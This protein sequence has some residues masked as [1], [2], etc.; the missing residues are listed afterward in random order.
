[1]TPECRQRAD[2]VFDQA[3][4]LEPSQWPAF[5]DSACAGDSALRAEVESMLGHYARAD[6]SGF[7]ATGATNP[8]DPGVTPA[9]WSAPPGY[10]ILTELGRGGMGVVYKARQTSL[11]RLVAIKKILH[12]DDGD[13]GEVKRLLLEAETIARFQ[14]P[15]IVQIHEV[16]LHAGSPFF[17]MELVE[18]GSLAQHCARGPLPPLQ[19][20]P[21]L[22]TLARAI[23]HAHRHGVVHRDLKPANVLL[24]RSPGCQPVAD[25]QAGSLGYEPKIADFGLAKRIDDGQQTRSGLIQGTPSYMAPEQTAGPAGAIGPCTDVYALGAILYECLTGRPPFRGASALETILLLRN[26]EPISP[27][28]LQ[29]SVPA[30]LE[31]ICLKCLDKDPGRRYDSGAAL[32]ADLERFLASEPIHAR[33]A[34]R[35]ERLLKWARRRPTAAALVIVSVLALIGLQAGVVWR[36]H[37]EKEVDAARVHTLM[38]AETAS[39]PRLIEELEPY[40]QRIEPLMWQYLADT[41][42]GSRERLHLHLALLPTHPD[43]AL[44]VCDSLLA[45]PLDDVPILRDALREHRQTQ[46]PRLW[47]VLEDGRQSPDSRFRAAVALSTYDSQENRSRWERNASFVAEQAVAVLSRKLVQFP[48]LLEAL[49]PIKGFLLTPLA[50]LFRNGVPNAKRRQATD[51]LAEMLA[52]AGADRSPFLAE[53]L[54]AAEPWQYNRLWSLVGS[55]QESLIPLLESALK[56]PPSWAWQDGSLASRLSRPDPALQQAV[57]DAEG[58]LDERFAFCQTMPLE[59]FLDVAEKLRPAGYRPLRVRPYAIDNRVQVAAVWKRD[60]KDWRLTTGKSAEEIRVQDSACQQQGYAAVDVAC[61]VTADSLAE[62]YTA[63]WCK[64]EA[65]EPASQLTVGETEKKFRGRLQ[66]L[67]AFSL[68]PRP[69]TLQRVTIGK[70]VARVNCVWR[71]TALAHT[72]NLEE[73]R[74][75]RAGGFQVDVSLWTP[76]DPAAAVK[77]AT[78]EYPNRNAPPPLE[79]CVVSKLPPTPHL[80]VCRDLATQGFRPTAI[81]A[82]SARVGDQPVTASVWA[83]PLIA[84][85]D[86]DHLARRQARAAITLLRLGRGQ[87]VWSL[88]RGGPEPR[89]RAQ[90]IHSLGPLGVPASELIARLRAATDLSEQRALVLALGEFPPDTQTPAA[91]QELQPWLLDQFRDHRDPGLHAAAGWLVRRWG[92]H[93]ELEARE[94]KLSRKDPVPDRD[95][96]VNGQ[97]QTMVVVRGANTVWM[98]SPVHEVNRGQG[99]R[100]HIQMLP[101]SFAIAATEVTQGQFNTFRSKFWYVPEWQLPDRDNVERPVVGVKWIDAVAYCQWLSEK[102][103][104]PRSQWCYPPISELK[105]GKP[106]EPVPGFLQ[107]TGYRLPTDAEWEFACRA[108]TRTSRSFGS[109]IEFLPRYAWFRGNARN[110]PQPVGRLAPNDL[111]LFDT[112]GNAWEW[113]HDLGA[114]RSGVLRGGTFDSSAETI[115]SAARIPASRDTMI[116][117]AGFRVAR[118]VPSR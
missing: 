26:Q 110:Q 35:A 7:L 9:P 80:I 112:Y 64:A 53:L 22:I 55:R 63:L 38:N 19:A 62:R 12:G 23:D 48:L 84:D 46:V 118:T 77:V 28:R 56:E 113:C 70:G 41:P 31:T 4:E 6:A 21:L 42:P 57:A 32:A 107:R 106:I 43:L 40:R 11:N 1:M 58:I 114:P 85:R 2:Q 14:H 90:L 49:G 108:G 59:R 37:K 75:W 52:D 5:L 61:Y 13:G 10:E 36:H 100:Q 103:N 97:R 34:G 16:G 87:Q 27:R 33:P 67:L 102:E 76:G 17:V 109:S 115:R 25:S 24:A 44:E 51:L 68:R 92:L 8:A 117:M 30:D 71:T 15:N 3:M 78:L 82:L 81:S 60:E 74:E 79:T 88:L 89:L 91:T 94:W 96:F 54:L 72:I 104:L 99:E 66:P 105:K 47:K 116:R 18:G 29:P 69:V 20:A 39:V 73:P 101:H 86:R 50:E 83:R 98:G 93:A 65:K 111:G 95:W 45:A